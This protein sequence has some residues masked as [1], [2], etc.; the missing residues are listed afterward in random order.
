MRQ[1]PLPNQSNDNTHQMHLHLHIFCN[2][3]SVFL[4]LLF[5]PRSIHLDPV[6]IQMFHSMLQKLL[7]QSIHFVLFADLGKQIRV[8]PWYKEDKRKTS[9]AEFQFA[10]SRLYHP[11]TKFVVHNTIHLDQI[12]LRH[13]NILQI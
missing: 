13:H 7:Y 8:T 10:Q 11:N 3:Q 1:I 12:F 6:H 4:Q 5:L 2:I 9:H